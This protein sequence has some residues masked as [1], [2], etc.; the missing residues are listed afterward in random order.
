MSEPGHIGQSAATRAH[1][2]V[3]LAVCG[4]AGVIL[5]VVDRV[6]GGWVWQCLV[7]GCVEHGDLSTADPGLHASWLM[8]HLQDRH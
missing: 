5:G 3:Q 4:P 7:K 1:T 8:D 6:A 2:V